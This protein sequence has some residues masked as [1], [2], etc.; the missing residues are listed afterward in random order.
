M[1][2]LIM[3]TWVGSA[4]AVSVD[5][6]YTADNIANTWY[7][8][9]DTGIA[10]NLAA[11]TNR[12]DWRKADMLSLDLEANSAY[13][14]IWSVTNFGDFSAGNPA[15]FLAQIDLGE[16]LVVSN[17]NWKY[18]LDGDNSSDFNASTWDWQ[19]VTEYGSNGGD[20]IWTDVNGGGPV[21]DISTD[22]QWIWSDLNYADGAE[23]KLFVRVDIKTAPV[24]EPATL[25]LLGSGLAGLAFLRRRKL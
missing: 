16:E 15:A 13:S 24:P 6:V 19:D 7:V 25:L 2:V 10:D 9:G 11:G 21:A 12:A 8:Q 20:N 3:L 14:L 1:L 17:V 18:S 4:M 23:Q 5:V 22:A